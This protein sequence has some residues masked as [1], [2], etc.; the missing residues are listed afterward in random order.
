MAQTFQNDPTVS[1]ATR[2]ESITSVTEPWLQFVWGLTA[3][4]AQIGYI[5][6]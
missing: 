2:S 5:T 1:V 3:L 4:S 6:P